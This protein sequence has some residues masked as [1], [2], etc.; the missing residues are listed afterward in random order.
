MRFLF[1]AVPKN[2]CSAA[3]FPTLVWALLA[4][5]AAWPMPAAPQDKPV[6]VEG[7]PFAPRL[8][9]AGGELLLNGT[10]VRAVAWF[11]GYAAG[12]YLSERASTAEQVQ[13]LAAP[14]RLQ[15][16]MLQ[17]VPASELAKAVRKGVNRNL[18]KEL[19]PAQRKTLEQQ[20]ELTETQINAVGKVRK[21]DVLDID[22]DTSGTLRISVNGTLRGSS[23]QASNLFAALLQAF[24]GPQP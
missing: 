9:V 14:K 22:Q 16:R 7:Q 13:A 21:G 17:E 1:F 5:A 15:L 12:L 6:V 4:L 18:P 19:S 23:S 2:A 3:V 8:S 10:G 11:K 20:L 24:V